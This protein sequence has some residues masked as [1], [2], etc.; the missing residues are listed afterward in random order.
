MQIPESL[1]VNAGILYITT[2]HHGTSL[3]LLGCENGI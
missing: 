3:H 1:G 2:A